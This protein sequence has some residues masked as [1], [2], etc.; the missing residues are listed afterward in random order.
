MLASLSLCLQVKLNMQSVITE[1]ATKSTVLSRPALVLKVRS[2]F[3][4]IIASQS[5]RD[6]ITENV[7]DYFCS[8]THR[9]HDMVMQLLHF[10]T[11]SH[12]HHVVI[13]KSFLQ[14]EVSSLKIP[15]SWFP[16]A[17]AKVKCHQ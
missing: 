4:Q 12:H 14:S 15:Q 2:S 1:W 3:Q 11:D 17:N 13:V 7:Y 6:I 16:G 5:I 9:A 8:Y 10:Y